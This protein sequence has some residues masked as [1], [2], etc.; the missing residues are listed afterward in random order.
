MELATLIDFYKKAIHL[1][2]F[3]G[4]Y[5]HLKLAI[6]YYFMTQIDLVL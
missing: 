6:Q 5:K 4:E 2:L 1:N 3:Y